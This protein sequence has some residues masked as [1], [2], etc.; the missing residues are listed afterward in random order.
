MTRISVFRKDYNRSFVT[1]HG[2]TT[3]IVAVEII[4]TIFRRAWQQ[5]TRKSYRCC[6]NLVRVLREW[7]DVVYGEEK[8]P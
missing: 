4:K 7:V 5:Y 3:D 2:N 1:S 6:A 8:Y